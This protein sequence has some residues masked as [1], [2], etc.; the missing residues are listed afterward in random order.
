MGLHPRLHETLLRHG[1]SEWQQPLHAPTRHAFE[2]LRIMLADNPTLIL[3]DSGCGTGESTLRLAALHPAHCVIGVDQSA[4]RL[5]RLAAKGI[6]RYGNAVLLRAELSS[7]WRLF[8]AAGWRAERHYLLYPNPWPKAAHLARRWHG[9]PV[10]PTLLGTA[11]S[12][13]LRS[14]WQVY[15]EEFAFALNL[16]GG[17]PASVEA[18]VCEQP[19]TPFERKYCAS[20]H[21][22]WRVRTHPGVTR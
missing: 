6:A 22:L 15:A 8:V 21:A 11:R 5:A 12:F 18:F 9:H 10:F 7:F 17:S 19:L 14:N 3:L 2:Q 16:L 20:G 4:V 1:R 13:E